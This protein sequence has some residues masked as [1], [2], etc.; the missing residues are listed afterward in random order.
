MLLF[1]MAL[2][3]AE[4]DKDTFE[5]IYNGYRKQMFTVAVGILNNEADAEDAVQEAFLGIA[6]SMHRVPKETAAQQRAY[7]LTVA[8]NAAFKVAREQKKWQAYIDIEN[9]S[10]S[11][12][13]DLFEQIVNSENRTRTM[14]LLAILPLQYREVLM[15]RYVYEMK[16]KEIGELLGRKVTTVQ[17]QLTR[18][19]KMLSALCEKEEIYSD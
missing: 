8:R 6:K 12:N 18:G 11:A 14:E 3:D 13:I 2:I 17:Q 19:K 15:L 5:E 4:E 1:Y 10:M 9:L 7:V 16:P